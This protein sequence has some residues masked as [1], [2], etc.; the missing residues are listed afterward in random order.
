[1]PTPGEESLIFLATLRPSEGGI[2]GGV[3]V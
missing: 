1:V 2:H 3:A